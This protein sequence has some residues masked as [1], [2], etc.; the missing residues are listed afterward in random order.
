MG[1]LHWIISISL[2]TYTFI[3]ILSPILFKL[4]FDRPAWWIQTAFRFLCHQRPER[5]IFLFG[6]KFTYSLSE[7]K[8]Y[9]Y[10]PRPLGYPFVGNNKIGYK[11]AFCTRDLFM[12][13]FMSLAGIFVSFYKKR[14]KIKWWV[15]ALMI[16]P[17]M[18]D[19]ITQFISEILII[20]QGNSGDVTLA[21][22]F[23]LSNN[24]TRAITGGFFGIGIGLFLISELKEAVLEDFME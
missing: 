3:P 11:I 5:S 22:P 20:S 14:V 7:L 21:N 23:Y 10:Q 9:G 24:L 8:D 6:E 1:N 18:A 13:S 19:G 16:I 12:Y 4:G 17:M 2:L 15:V